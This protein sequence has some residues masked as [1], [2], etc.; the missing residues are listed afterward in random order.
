MSDEHSEIRSLA[1]SHPQNSSTQAL[2][3]CL[4]INR[5]TFQSS[6]NTSQSGKAK[7]HIFNLLL[8]TNQSHQYG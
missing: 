5:G 1:L 6:E 8:I 3:L 2:E 4:F 7:M